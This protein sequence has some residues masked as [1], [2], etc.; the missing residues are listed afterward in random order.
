[1]IKY[2]SKGSEDIMDKKTKNI[3]TREQVDK[4][5]RNLNKDLIDLSISSS[6]FTGLFF[7]ASFA[8]SIWAFGTS[9]FIAPIKILLCLASFIVL[10]PFG[11]D[12]YDLFKYF[13]EGKKISNG[14]YEIIKRDMQYK[15]K[16]EYLR[17]R[18]LV[19]KRLLHFYDFKEID[20]NEIIYE[21]AFSGEEYYIVHLKNSKE[22]KMLYSTERYE[23]KDYSR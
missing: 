11:N 6:I 20:V 5:L 4:E 2:S 22:I 23:I 14:D 17:G 10:F 7:G 1:M 9:N 18:H 15:N 19:T 3:I 16:I 8:V 21:L 12:V 13:A